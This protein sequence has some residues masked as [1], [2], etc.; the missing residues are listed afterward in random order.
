[1]KTL[2]RSWLKIIKIELTA[3]TAAKD[4]IPELLRQIASLVEEGYLSGN[5]PEWEMKIQ[6]RE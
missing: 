3:K 2:N 6:G 1:M 5:Y 4:D